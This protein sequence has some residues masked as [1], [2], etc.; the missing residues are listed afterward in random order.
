MVW[1]RVVTAVLVTLSAILGLIVGSFLNVVIARVPAGES[2]VAPASRC[3][4]CATAIRPRDNIPLLS[5]LLLR[6]RCRACAAPISWR[7]PAVEA[8]TAVAFA[9]IVWRLGARW[10]TPAYLYIAAVGIALAV[11]D[12]DTRR[13]PN[14]LTLPSY[15][16]GAVLLTGAAAIEHSWFSLARAATGL[17]ALY[18]LYFI[19]AVAKSGGMGFGDVK[20]AGVVGMFLGFLGW[21]PLVVGAFLM[22]FLGGLGG[23]VLMAVGRAGRK[24]KIPFGPFIVAGTLIAVL[25]GEPLTTLYRHAFLA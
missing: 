20:L 16:V 1:S 19:L 12:L 13:L 10:E 9:A 22:F 24:T 8:M 25:A 18:A 6:G 23:V 15:I 14:V 4:R 5:W 7:Y 3:P 2:V 11:I 17:V 21:G